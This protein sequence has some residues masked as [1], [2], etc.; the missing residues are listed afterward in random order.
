MTK[1]RKAVGDMLTVVYT[2][3]IS[4]IAFR[5]HSTLIEML[6]KL[7]VAQTLHVYH[8]TN[9]MAAIR[10]TYFLS[11]QFHKS[12]LT[13]F[14]SKPRPIALLMDETTDH[15]SIKTLSVEIMVLE[16]NYPVTYFYRL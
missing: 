4:N 13:H 3:A 2:E 6:D 14:I 15:M 1:A 11:K 12:F 10:M 9:H 8:H 5:C 7:G 16:N